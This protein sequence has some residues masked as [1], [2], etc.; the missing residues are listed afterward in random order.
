MTRWIG[1]ARILVPTDFSESS[2]AALEY[3]CTLAGLFGARL[4][5]L[6]VR[7]AVR[8]PLLPRAFVSAP[9]AHD[10]NTCGTD[11]GLD[12]TERLQQL[13][14]HLT[15]RVPLVSAFI[16]RGR[17]DEEILAFAERDHSE[18]IVMGSHGESAAPYPLGTIATSVIT[19]A[20]CPVLTIPSW[21]RNLH[22]TGLLWQVH[23]S[24]NWAS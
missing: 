11:D 20:T 17:A 23:Q 5:V 2:L 4:S 1:A 19:Q 21:T 18:L 9:L 10:D 6:H 24:S 13:L 15:Q 3:G 14:F 8:H 16:A 7:P 22:Q 12:V